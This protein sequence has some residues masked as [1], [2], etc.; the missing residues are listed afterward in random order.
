[1]LLLNLFYFI[2]FYLL[3]PGG[4]FVAALFS[5]NLV[6]LVP[7][8]RAQNTALA[9]PAAGV[10]VRRIKWLWAESGLHLAHRG[11]K[12]F[13]LV[14][15]VNINGISVVEKRKEVQWYTEFCT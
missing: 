13:L 6:S 2:F 10:L 11:G 12:F 15:S 14:S 1:M 7:L 8:G 4:K 9:M 5:D 3:T